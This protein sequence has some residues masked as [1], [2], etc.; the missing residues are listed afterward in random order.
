VTARRKSKRLSI[1]LALLLGVV[2]NSGAQS[3]LTKA[4]QAH[5]RYDLA[6]EMKLLEAAAG[7]ASDED[8]AEAERRLAWLAWRF[9]KDDQAARKHFERAESIDFGLAETLA[10]RAAMETARGRFEEARRL[11]R[12]AFDRAGN[13][14][15]RDDARIAFAAATVEEAFATGKSAAAREALDLIAQTVRSEPGRFVPSRLM[16]GLAM[17]LA[18]KERA[19]DALR[20]YHWE[21]DPLP[22]YPEAGLAGAPV[23]VATYARFCRRVKA[24]ADEH[25]RRFAINETASLHTSLREPVMAEAR[26]IWPDAATEESLR[27]ILSGRFGAEIS[28]ERWGLAYGH[29]VFDREQEFAQYGQKVRVRFVVLDSMVSSGY[30]SWF[31]GGRSVIGGWAGP[32]MVQ[33]RRE[34]ALRAWAGLTDPERKAEFDR[35]IARDSEGDEAAAQRNPYAYLPGLMHRV[36][37]RAHRE[38]YAKL[39]ARGLSSTDLRLAFLGELQSQHVGC[40]QAHEA[41]HLIDRRLGTPNTPGGQLEMTAALSQVLFGPNP[42]VCLTGILGPNIGVRDNSSGE[43]N[44]RIMQ[45][46]VRWMDVYASEI[47][48]LESTRPLLP[49]LDLLSGDQIRAAFR[50]MDPLAT[51]SAE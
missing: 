33:V 19:R 16:Y 10:V 39:Q 28:F 31:S 23:D 8:R 46:I 49:Q 22:L 20:S 43:G 15:E 6:A 35:R 12:R 51:R 18:D 5:T 11:A 41:R 40:V 17:L 13:T 36:H 37:R 38:I 3:L 34:D 50:S 24:I 4:E 45:G 14:R 25:Y 21:G 26:K 47:K 9:Y 29:R 30:V 1:I 32:P 7:S 27:T 48:G 44:G 42:V 2:A